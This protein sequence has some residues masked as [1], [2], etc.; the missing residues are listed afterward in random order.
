MNIEK[1]MLNT[2]P[3]RYGKQ[4]ERQRREAGSIDDPE[5]VFV[6]HVAYVAEALLAEYVVEEEVRHR[7]VLACC[8]LPQK[9]SDAVTEHGPG[10]RTG[11]TYRSEAERLFGCAQAQRNEQYIGR[12][13]EPA[14]LEQCEKEQCHEAPTALAPREHPVI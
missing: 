12:Q 2:P 13:R 5:V 9:E 14:R 3:R 6:V 11:E 10:N 8:R 7:G 1:S 4:L